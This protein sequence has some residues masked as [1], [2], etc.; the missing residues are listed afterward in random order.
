M[1]GYAL[2]AGVFSDTQHAEE[3]HARLTRE[4]I[5][6]SIEA[7][8]QVGPFKSKAEAEA[9][10]KKLNALGID[11]VLLPPKKGER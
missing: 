4:G 9:T 6:S 8:V 3:L 11:S 1:S 10:G 7:R 5:P 2:Q